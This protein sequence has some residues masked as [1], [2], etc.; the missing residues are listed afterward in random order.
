LQPISAGSHVAATRAR[1][2]T[3]YRAFLVHSRLRGLRIERYTRRERERERKRE[4]ER[5]KERDRE[6]ERERESE[7]KREREREREKEREKNKDRHTCLQVLRALSRKVR[8]CERN[9][10]DFSE[11][12]KRDGLHQHL[13]VERKP[14]R[15]QRAEPSFAKVM[16]SGY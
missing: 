4:K 7:R 8:R 2:Y 13:G 14:S 11:L 15:R 9:Y 12:V 5:E 10:E 6:R 3:Y 16:T 1:R